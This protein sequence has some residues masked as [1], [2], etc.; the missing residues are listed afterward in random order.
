MIIDT[1][2]GPF[3]VECGTD[4]F[5]F[6]LAGSPV[7]PR[8]LNYVE[9]LA[10]CIAK[11][12]CRQVSYFPPGE[13]LH[14]HIARPDRAQGIEPVQDPVQVPGGLCYLK[15]NVG[16]PSTNNPNV[17]GGRL[18]IGNQTI[19]SR[20][21]TASMTATPRISAASSISATSIMSAIQTT[22]YRPVSI[23]TTRAGNDHPYPYGPDG[24]EPPK[25]YYGNVLTCPYADASTYTSSCG[26]Q[27]AIECFSDRSGNDLYGNVPHVSSLNE[28]V[29]ACDD[30]PGCLAVSYRPGADGPCYM[31]GALGALTRDA[32][33]WGARQISGCTSQHLLKG[34]HRKRVV[35]SP[36]AKRAPYGPD[37]TYISSTV[38]STITST[39]TSTTSTLT[40]TSATAITVTI[41]A[42][43]TAFVTPAVTTI[44]PSTVVVFT[45]VTT[46]ANVR[47]F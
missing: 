35:H 27:Y 6:D 29:K 37:F 19:S 10:C 24:P 1:A 46:C 33:I 36:L 38:T 11:I 17:I 21:S 42:T 28:C 14:A 39:T 15:G 32:S 47:L 20:V 30:T 31:K 4:R 5:Q 9:C 34:L 41:T 16:T 26:A 45:T 43:A 12:E 7:F 8:P 40:V 22:I 23:T 44:V 13:L 2:A 25:P 18:L 3:E